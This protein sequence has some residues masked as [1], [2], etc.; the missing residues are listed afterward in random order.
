MQAIDIAI[1]IRSAWSVELEKNRSLE[2]KAPSGAEAQCSLPVFD[3]RAEARTL[4]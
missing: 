4:P 2:E 3:V 1:T